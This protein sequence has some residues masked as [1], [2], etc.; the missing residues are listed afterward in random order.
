MNMFE[1]YEAAGLDGSLGISVPDTLSVYFEEDD[2]EYVPS[3]D[4]TEADVL[5]LIE[6]SRKAGRNLFKEE[7]ELFKPEPGC[8]Y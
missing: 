7:W 4:V 6:R 2:S 3:E 1:A 8:I 5:D